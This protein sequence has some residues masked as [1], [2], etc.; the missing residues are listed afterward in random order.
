MLKLQNFGIWEAFVSEELDYPSNS[1][2]MSASKREKIGFIIIPIL[3]GRLIHDYVI[4]GPARPGPA[5]RLVRF[6]RLVATA[7]VRADSRS[8][9]NCCRN[10]RSIAFPIIA[11]HKLHLI[12]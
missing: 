2:R 9:R 11:C 8:T 12:T 4:A 6:L 10:I 5:A 3:G 7:S 1:L